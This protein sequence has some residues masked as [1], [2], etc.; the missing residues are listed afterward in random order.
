MIVHKV[1]FNKFKTSTIET[2]KQTVNL[3]EMA[4]KKKKSNIK[5]FQ[6]VAND[7]GKM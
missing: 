6:L 1:L 4:I 2:D 5:G 3:R 7:E